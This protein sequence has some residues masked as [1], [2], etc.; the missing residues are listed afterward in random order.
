MTPERRSTANYRLIAPDYF[1]T[2][3]IPMK[4]GREFSIGD[5]AGSLAVA[6]I[7]EQLARRYL[8]DREVLG[9]LCW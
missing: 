4:A 9:A 6:I 2:M 7:S 5:E 1:R 3:R 8:G